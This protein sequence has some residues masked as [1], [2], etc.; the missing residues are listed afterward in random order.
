MIEA[1]RTAA[2][3][4][5]SLR[6]AIPGEREREGGSKGDGELAHLDVNLLGKTKETGRRRNGVEARSSELEL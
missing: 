4:G 3:R 5:H 1:G 6:Q 2:A